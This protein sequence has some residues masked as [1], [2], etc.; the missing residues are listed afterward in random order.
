[1]SLRLA[2]STATPTGMPSAS[3]SRLRLTPCLARSVG[4][5]PVFFPPEGRLGHAPVHR[6]PRPVDAFAVVVG[7]QA[8]LPH[9]LEDAGLH[10]FLEAVVG[11]GPGA[12]D[13][14]V[15]GFPLTAGAEDEEDGLHA[16][17]VGLSRP[18]AAL[19]AWVLF[20]GLTG[21]WCLPQRSAGSAS[22]RVK[23]P[24]HEG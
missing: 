17:P 22:R 8:D 5:W 16:G 7:H 10:P 6:Q 12:E 20:R 13:G 3:T 23:A 21:G 4:F 9:L 15:Q 2:P 24:L 14:G 11:R 1:M 18:P 19:A